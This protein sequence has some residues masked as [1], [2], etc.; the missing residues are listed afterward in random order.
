MYAEEV[1]VAVKKST[2]LADSDRASWGHMESRE[3]AA[4]R[5]EEPRCNPTG[6]IDR[7]ETCNAVAWC[8]IN[9]GLMPMKEEERTEPSVQGA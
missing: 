5:L 3:S 2:K 4:A 7:G 8:F 9:E 6:G 1:S